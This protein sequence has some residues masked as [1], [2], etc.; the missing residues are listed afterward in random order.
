MAFRG[1]FDYTPRREEP[2]H[3]PGQVPGRA[4]REGVVLAKGIER[5]VRGLD[6]RATTRPTPTALCRAAT[7]SRPRR[8]S[9]R[10]SSR[11]LARHRAR[12]RRP[13]DGARPSCSSTPACDKEVVVTGAGDCLEV[14]DRGAWT[15][16][17]RRAVRRAPRHRRAPS[18]I[19]LDM[20]TDARPGPRRRADRRCST[21][22]RARSPSTARSAAAVTRAWSPSA[23]G[24]TGTLIAIDRDPV[25]EERFAELAAEV[26]CRHALHPRA[27][28]ADGA[29]ASSRDEGVARRPRLPRPRH[30][31]DAG[32]HARARLLLRLRRAAGHAH[33]PR[34]GAHARRHRQRRGTS[35]GWRALLREYGEERYARPIARAI[36]RARARRRRS[37]RRNELVDVI[38]AAI[39]AP[40]RFAGGHP[41]KRIFQA[42]RIAVNDELGQLDAALPA[43]LGA[44]RARTADLPGF[45]STRSKTAA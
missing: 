5:C 8:A 23:S 4:R 31:L 2:A 37:R 25:A 13:R 7:R 12:L 38:T 44:A 34:R 42:I 30:V 28:F 36:V 35:A 3:G 32:R 40:A 10:A 1:T 45:P 18:A 29:R 43:G 16:L 39:P 9:S 14:W 17:Q 26:A 33:G 19:L 27:T 41:A 20:T 11:Q 22:S 15:D 21:R 6:A 24:P